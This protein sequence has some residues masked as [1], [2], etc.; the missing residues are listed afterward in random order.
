MSFLDV[1]VVVGG[2]NRLYDLFSS[3]YANEFLGSYIICIF[4]MYFYMSLCNIPFLTSSRTAA[5]ICF[6]FCVDVP[7]VDPYKVC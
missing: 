5:R 1:A 4:T 3:N 6:K 2:V 7:L